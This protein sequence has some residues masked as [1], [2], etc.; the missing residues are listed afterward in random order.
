MK[1]SS[2]SLKATKSPRK[3]RR[4][5]VSYLTHL[6]PSRVSS[7][8][9]MLSRFSS[10]IPLL[11]RFSSFIPLL[12]RFLSFIPL[13]S[14]FSSSSPLSGRT[15]Y[16]DQREPAPLLARQPTIDQIGILAPL[17]RA[18]AVDEDAPNANG[19]GLG[20]RVQGLGFRA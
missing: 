5:G 8:V 6:S 2:G 9:P 4:G 1:F 15:K 10:F 3:A 20:F 17:Y 11:S 13:L 14:R 18:G 16:L 12:S 19:L 7:R